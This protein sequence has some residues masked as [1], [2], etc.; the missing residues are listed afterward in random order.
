M[1]IYVL[2][3]NNI[4]FYIGKSTK[5]KN[6][7]WHHKQ[8][9]GQDITQT[10]LEKVN[11]NEW[12]FWECYWIEQFT[13]WGFILENKNKGGGGPTRWD[14]KWDTQERKNAISNHPT[15]GNNISKSLINHSQHYTPQI[16]KKMSESQKG[17][18]KPFSPQH[19]KNI[20][21][22]KRKNAKPVLQYDLDGNFIKEWESKG[23]IAKW[24][25]KQTGRASNL[26]SQI[27][28]CILGRQKTCCGFI[29]KYKKQ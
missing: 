18:P 25:K 13:S 10:I 2:E 15:R 29:F 27:K 9:F 1:N 20:G 19:V 5:P 16:R 17:I 23:E 26:T 4:P 12:K 24:L 28:D 22:A 14:S 3:K 8:K 11:E 7:L 6:R 21:I